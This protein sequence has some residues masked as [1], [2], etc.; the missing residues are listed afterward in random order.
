MAP[1][2]LAENSSMVRIKDA[3]YE[4]ALQIVLNTAFVLCFSVVNQHA[5]HMSLLD[6]DI[7]SALSEEAQT[8]MTHRVISIVK[9]LLA[10]AVLNDKSPDVSNSWRTF[11]LWCAHL[12][13]FVGASGL[14]GI[15]VEYL[16]SG[17]SKTFLVQLWF[18]NKF[19]LRRP[20]VRKSNL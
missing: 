20:Q 18:S 6:L 17:M 1:S 16:L 19:S 7:Y 15:R 5:W 14:L 13:V 10:C 11:A 8:A 4:G 12:F 3:L 9:V 2:W